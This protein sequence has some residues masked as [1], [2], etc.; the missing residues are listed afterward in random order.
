MKNCTVLFENV[1]LIISMLWAGV[2]PKIY[3]SPI[4]LFFGIL[5]N[6]LSFVVLTSRALRRVSTYNYLAV[7]SV[8]DSLVLLIGL[9]PRWL[10]MAVGGDDIR[11]HSLL[12]CRVSYALSMTVSDYAVWL[13]VAVTVDRYVAVVHSLSASTYCTRGRALKVSYCILLKLLSCMR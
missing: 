9:L 1:L 12:I 2:Q 10:A 6:T 8:A 13:L 11:D 7:L 3:V 4:I 5:G